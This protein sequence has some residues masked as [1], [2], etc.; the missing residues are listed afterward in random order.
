MSITCARSSPELNGTDNTSEI[1]RDVMECNKKPYLVLTIGRTQ[2]SG[3]EP[4]FPLYL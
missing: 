4:N 2:E 1:G 3:Q